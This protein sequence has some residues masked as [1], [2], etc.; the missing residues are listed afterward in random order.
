MAGKC[1]IFSAPSGSGK[2]TIVNHLVKIEDLKLQF[3]VSACSRKIREGEVHGKDYF[4]LSIDEFRTYIDEDKF[5][6]WEEVYKNHYY[7]TLKTEVDRIFNN[8]HNIIFDVDV[9]GGMNLKRKFGK[10][11]LSV[12]V[13]PPSIEVLQQRLEKR[14]SDP[15]DKIAGRIAKAK[16]EMKYAEK[17]DKVLIN[18]DLDKALKEAEEMIREFLKS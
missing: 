4:F 1:I 11:A 14:G 12:F 2:T 15:A 8:N 9:M 6:E 17:F 10:E 16:F 3:S 5:I 13:M 7:G 18:D